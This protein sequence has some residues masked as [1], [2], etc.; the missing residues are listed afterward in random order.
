LD[1]VTQTGRFIVA[2]LRKVGGEDA[3]IFGG[4]SGFGFKKNE[5]YSEK[6]SSH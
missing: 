4:D 1:I 2:S 3:G 5:K 6:V